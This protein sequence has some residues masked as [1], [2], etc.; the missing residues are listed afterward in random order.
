MR[1]MV[2]PRR[3][4]GS[5]VTRNVTPTEGGVL[6]SAVSFVPAIVR[7]F[8]P[9]PSDPSRASGEGGDGSDP[10]FFAAGAA[11]RGGGYTRCY[12]GCY[13]PPPLGGRSRLYS[14]PAGRL[15]ARPTRRAARCLTACS[16]PCSSW[17]A[18]TPSAPGRGRARSPRPIPCRSASRSATTT[19]VST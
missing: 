4:H 18:S 17:A 8:R 15:R 12:I 6:H 1:R 13:I 19:A 14:I 16:A 5:G 3:P 10:P 9:R 2:W 11:R 7:V